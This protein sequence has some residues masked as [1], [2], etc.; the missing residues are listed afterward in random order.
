MR[1]LLCEASTSRTFVYFGLRQ[2]EMS[3]TAASLIYNTELIPPG[4]RRPVSG[5]QNCRGPCSS[6]FSLGSAGTLKWKTPSRRVTQASDV[7]FPPTRIP[8]SQAPLALRL[9][10]GGGPRTPN[11]PPPL[12]GIGW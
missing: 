6:L 3:E 11:A 10:S 12:A 2:E 5:Q 4:Q 9:A 8:T 1:S 7:I